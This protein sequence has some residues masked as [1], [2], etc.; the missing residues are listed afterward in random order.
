MFHDV[1]SKDKI[2]K[3]FATLP[4][5]EIYFSDMVVASIFVLYSNDAVEVRYSDGSRLQL[6]PCGS[7]MCHQRSSNVP[8]P[9]LDD[10]I[11]SKYY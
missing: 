1:L 9:E 8:Q 10:D 2:V 5:K 7:S 4:F 11:I 6:S 3:Q